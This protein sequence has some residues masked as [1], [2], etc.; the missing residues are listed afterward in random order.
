MA[1]IHG[2]RVCKNQYARKYFIFLLKKLVK[3]KMKLIK[4]Q[5]REGR[6]GDTFVRGP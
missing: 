4:V 3:N 5:H 1:R 6:Q 2:A